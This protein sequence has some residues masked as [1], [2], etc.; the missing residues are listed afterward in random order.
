MATM[1][2]RGRVK[3]ISKQAAGDIPEASCPRPEPGPLK[4]NKNGG[5]FLKNPVPFLLSPFGPAVHISLISFGHN[6][7]IR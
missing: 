4:P 3:A 6:A 5:G 1:A 7:I 2:I